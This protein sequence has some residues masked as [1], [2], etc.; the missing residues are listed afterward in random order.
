M[1]ATFLLM[2]KDPLVVRCRSL[3]G[4]MPVLGV[5]CSVCHLLQ[6]PGDPS[7]SG[8]FLTKPGICPL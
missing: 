2:V 6:G 5:K 7:K 1:E 4:S 8:G 3:L